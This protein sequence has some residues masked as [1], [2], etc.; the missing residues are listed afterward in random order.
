MSGDHSRD[1]CPM[2]IVND[3]GGAFAMGAIGG[4]IWHSVKGFR[5]SPV[6]ERWQGVKSAVRLRAPTL[7]G[8]FG[9]WGGM[10]SFFDCTVKA[11]RKTEDPWNSI[12]SGF[13]VGGA[14]A[15]RG[16]WKHMRNSAIICGFILAG[17]EGA[18]IAMSRMMAENPV[19]PALPEAPL[20]A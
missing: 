17:M 5:N 6:G 10:F 11:V 13:L 15:V 3:F 2:V 16:G 4:T 18:G 8:N 9:A 12:I 14:L 7:G 19:A 1:P 20:A